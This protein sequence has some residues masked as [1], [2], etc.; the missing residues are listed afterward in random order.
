[1][2]TMTMIEAIRSTIR[3]EILRDEKVMVLGQDIGKLGGVFRA[4]EGLQAEFGEDR[5]V[6]MPLA[7]ASIVGSAVGLSLSGLNPIAEIQ[8]LGFAQQAYHQ[9]VPQL[10]RFR[11]RSQGRYSTGV[12]IRAPFGGGVRA[13]ELHSDAIESQFTSV[14]GLQ[15]VL[16]S[17]PA[18]AKGLLTTAIRSEDPVLFC[19]PLKGYR[20]VKGD[21]PDDDYSIPFGEL[22]IAR[23][24]TDVT[25]FAW[26]A[27]VQLAEKAAESL[28]SEGISAQV[29]DLR[30][31]VPLDVDG[32]REVVSATGRAVVIHEAPLTSG[33]GAEVVSTIQE[34]AFYSLEAPVAR[35]AAPDVPYPNIGIE[36]VFIPNVDRVVS[37]V[38]E[39]VSAE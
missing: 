32:I 12:T 7:E 27:A 31:L 34:E 25:L 16:P 2:T 36:E 33:Y 11:F 18:D 13:P 14:P 38:R 29:V 8:F 30:T 23:E 35:V 21:V 3:Q 28:A 6:D 17:T 10:A 15:V 20:L 4:T 19:E 22:R 39:V 9:I 37:A 1:M 26:S 24:G 5:I